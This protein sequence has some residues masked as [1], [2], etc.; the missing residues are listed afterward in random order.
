MHVYM[1]VYGPTLLVCRTIYLAVPTLPKLATRLGSLDGVLGQLGV[2]A[3][4]D[5]GFPLLG[6]TCEIFSGWHLTIETS[7]MDKNSACKSSEVSRMVWVR[8]YMGKSPTDAT[9]PS[10]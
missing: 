2:F 6:I 3:Y 8:V 5:D 4:I 1:Y 7:Q 10:T 9:T